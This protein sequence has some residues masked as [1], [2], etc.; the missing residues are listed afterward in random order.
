MKK[1]VG[2]LLLLTVLIATSCFQEAS[3]SPKVVYKNSSNSAAVFTHDGTQVS[4]KEFL[5]GN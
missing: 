3:T 4:G 5:Q 2:L 1:Y